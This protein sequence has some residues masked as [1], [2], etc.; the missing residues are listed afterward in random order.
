MEKALGFLDNLE[1]QKKSEFQKQKYRLG[2][3]VDQKNIIDNRIVDYLKSGRED[4]SK[5]FFFQEPIN[6]SIQLSKL[7]EKKIVEEQEKLDVV[8]AE[9][10]KIYLKKRALGALKE[11][12]KA[13]FRQEQNREE[14]K[15]MDEIAVC[16]NP[17]GAVK[18]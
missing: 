9:L 1:S 12:K 3:F 15:N 8:A 11:K 2:Y 14:Q 16:F 13:D 7:L 17:R 5:T 10:N 6:N 4:F 18:L